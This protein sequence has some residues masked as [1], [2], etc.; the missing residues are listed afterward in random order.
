MSRWDGS[1]RRPLWLPVPEMLAG[2]L[3]EPT[4]AASSGTRSERLRVIGRSG[5]LGVGLITA[6]A[7]AFAATAWLWDK[8]R[9][10]ERS[11]LHQLASMINLG[12]LLKESKACGLT[13]LQLSRFACLGIEAADSVGRGCCAG[14][15]DS[16]ADDSNE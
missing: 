16:L 5:L 6:G 8:A 9:Q 4:V 11:L 10:E 2:K 1:P 14:R 3:L 7:A 12:T 15:R 13:F